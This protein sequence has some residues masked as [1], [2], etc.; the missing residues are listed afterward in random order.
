[1]NTTLT[2]TPLDLLHRTAA[3]SPTS[4][5]LYAPDGT[6]TDYRTLAEHVTR[7][8]A[9]L[10]AAGVCSGDRVV[11]RLPNDVPAVALVFAAWTIGAIAVPLP[12]ST[13]DIQLLS[14]T[15]DCSASLVVVDAAPDTVPTDSP[16]HLTWSAL[17]TAEV[18]ESHTQS[19]VSDTEPALL[20]YT[21]GSTSK[22]KGVICPATA[23][24]F[25]VDSIGRRL[26]YRD[27]DIVL[28]MSPL[29]F[30]YGLYQ[31][32][33]SFAAGASVVLA[34]ASNALGLLRTIRS[35]PVTVVPAVPAVAGM[36]HS[37]LSRSGSIDTVRLV[38]STGAD[39]PASR[40]A[41]LRS[42]FPNAGIVAMYGITE[43]KRVTIAEPDI[44]RYRPGAVGRAIPGTR[45][46]ILDDSGRPV[47]TGTDG[48]IVSIG[49]HVMDGYWGADQLTAERF[50]IDPTTGEKVLYTGDY[51]RV[52]SEGYLYFTGRRDD[53]FKANGVRTSVSEISAA[54]ES[55]ATVQAVIV[56]KPTDD[57]GL[58]I[59]VTATTSASDVLAAL[60]TLLE[61][62]KIP[63][64]CVVLDE[65][66]LTTNGKVDT[67]R[68]ELALKK[69]TP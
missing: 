27:T 61:P 18:L 58:A 54:V 1:M 37:L 50:G 26:E 41:E 43:C 12:P 51:G 10:R 56:L 65:L 31:V 48:Q 19:A 32:L 44:D 62:A 4:I 14:V 20:M 55:L 46:V 25:A 59:V 17:D 28:L 52:D 7:A 64:R 6:A 40:I 35:T 63:T 47:P 22:P 39:L 68:A 3:T 9:A 8:A 33:L 29:S 53:I 2:S 69:D 24:V 11:T 15:A 36:L 49:P 23:I 38:T 66:P 60:A 45:L 42:V 57:H 34:D 21:S 13:T 67:R 5:A 30:D 16:P